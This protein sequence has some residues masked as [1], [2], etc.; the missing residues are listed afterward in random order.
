M[1]L[2]YLIKEIIKKFSGL[3]KVVIAAP[4][5]RNEQESSPMLCP[6]MATAV[7]MKVT[8]VVSITTM[9]SMHRM[10]KKLCFVSKVLMM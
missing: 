8:N 4:K 7:M 3:V 9:A 2:P 10:W 5:A 1:K 6:D